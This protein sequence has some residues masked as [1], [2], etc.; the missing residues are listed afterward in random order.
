[1]K[2]AVTTTIHEI[3]HQYFQSMVASDEVEEPWIDEGLTSYY[4]MVVADEL[5]GRPYRIFGLAVD[6]EESS[7]AAIA[8]TNPYLDPIVK[9]CWAFAS[10]GSYNMSSYMRPALTFRHLERLLGEARFDRAMRRTFQAWRW[11]HP[12]TDD[13]L[14]T[15][16]EASNEDLSWFFDQTM[17]T[18]QALD[19][20]LDRARSTP[21][22]PFEGYTWIDGKRTLITA[23]ESDSDDSSGNSSGDSSDDSSD[24]SPGD[25][26]S[27]E[28]ED[29]ATEDSATE[30]GTGDSVEPIAAE[31]IA[32]E[33]GA[34]EPGAAEPGVGEPEDEYETVVMVR[35][36]GGIRHPVEV[37][38][39]FDDGSS[40]RL[41]W[42]GADRW[43]RWRLRTEHKV[44][45]AELDPDHV[46]VLDV[47]RLDNSLRAE[48][49]PAA[50]SK[51]LTHFIFWLQNLLAASDI[52]G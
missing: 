11:H 16:S 25:D 46:M 14:A 45:E 36:I 7:H 30:D 2:W 4:E 10:N 21:V 50:S 40:T 39:R 37:E 18:D 49:A 20:R 44:V 26:S 33:P 9:P 6:T 15:I 3:G 19:Y 42:D 35:R 47:N 32:A 1:M 51:I 48:P 17:R 34:A 5:Y 29:S 28:P 38:L 13:L 31:P 24:D 52:L 8:F 22:T 27:A 43:K 41:A 23:D 12:S